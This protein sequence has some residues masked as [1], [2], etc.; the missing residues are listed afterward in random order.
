MTKIYIAGKI[1]GDLEYRAKFAAVEE[2][3]RSDPRN[4]V[5]NPAVL[6]ARLE[7]PDYMNICH[8][9]LNAADRVVF[10]PD[11]R[12]SEGALL[13]MQYCQTVRKPYEVLP[14][15]DPA[16]VAGKERYHD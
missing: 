12:Y 8:A 11:Y 14:V 15:I 10:F 5:I 7:Y 1:T 6:P 4:V 9:M 3:L 13:E 16:C 2:R